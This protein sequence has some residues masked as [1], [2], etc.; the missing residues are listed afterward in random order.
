M[1][2]TTRCGHQSN[3]SWSSNLR[4][5]ANNLQTS[6]LGK[7]SDNLQ[8]WRTIGHMKFEENTGIIIIW[9][10]KVKVWLLFAGMPGWLLMTSLLAANTHTHHLYLTLQPKNPWEGKTGNFCP[11]CKMNFLKY[12]ANYISQIGSQHSHT[13]PLSNLTP[14]NPWEGKTRKFC[15]CPN[16]NMFLSKLE[17]E[18]P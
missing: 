3:P 14:A 4:K 8:N 6:N 16:W 15:I 2:G 9:M 5:Y 7:T 11:E 18:F 13:S 17:N 10:K 1:Y 12:L